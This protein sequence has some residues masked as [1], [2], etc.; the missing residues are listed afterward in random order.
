MSSHFVQSN[1]HLCFNWPDRMQQKYPSIK[2]KQ[3]QFFLTVVLSTFRLGEIANAISIVTL[4]YYDFWNDL[5]T[6]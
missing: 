2:I 5:M 4:K 6:E 3:W 1:I